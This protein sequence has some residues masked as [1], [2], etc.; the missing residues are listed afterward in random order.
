MENLPNL[1][2][3]ETLSKCTTV[4]LSDLPLQIIALQATEQ[5]SQSVVLPQMETFR[6]QV[7]TFYIILSLL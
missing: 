3:A 5:I 4:F 1:S 2:I 6:S 7:Y